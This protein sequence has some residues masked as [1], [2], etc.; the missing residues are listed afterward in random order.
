MSVA[1]IASGSHGAFSR[2]QPDLEL[3]ELAAR[4][5]ETDPAA[6]L[7]NQDAHQVHASAAAGVGGDAVGSGEPGAADQCHRLT[8]I[9]D[10]SL[11]WRDQPALDCDFFYALELQA[12]A[13]VLHDQLVAVGVAR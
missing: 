2:R 11:Q 6:E 10:P 8:R 4:R 1:A 13:V 9:A 7:G 5:S 3:G 12:A